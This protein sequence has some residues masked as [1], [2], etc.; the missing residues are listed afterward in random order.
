M[1]LLGAHR[2]R[3]HRGHAMELQPQSVAENSSQGYV[4]QTLGILGQGSLSNLFL[5][6]IWNYLT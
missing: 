4:R 6:D 3:R 2:Y 1:H 5:G